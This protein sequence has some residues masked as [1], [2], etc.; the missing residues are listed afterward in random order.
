MEKKRKKAGTYIIAA[1]LLAAGLLWNAA[2]E[3]NSESGRLIKTLK[4][5]GYSLTRDELHP[6]G[7]WEEQSISALLSE[8]KLN[9]AVEASKAAGFSSDIERK[10]TVSLIMADAGGGSVLTLYL[11]NGEIELAF[12]QNPGSFDVLPLGEA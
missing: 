12:V 5:Y 11:V 7:T 10:G 9:K 6:I 3:R 8:V 1:V 4:S 2:L